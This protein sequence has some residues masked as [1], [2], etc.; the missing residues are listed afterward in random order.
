MTENEAF[1]AFLV[2]IGAAGDPD[3]D[4]EALF[5]EWRKPGGPDRLKRMLASMP[6]G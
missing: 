1:E 5:D 3:T 6:A 4:R 2:E